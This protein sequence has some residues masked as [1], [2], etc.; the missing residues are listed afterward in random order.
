MIIKNFFYNFKLNNHKMLLAFIALL[1]AILFSALFI[2]LKQ[3]AAYFTYELNSKEGLKINLSLVN[4]GIST[5]SADPSNKLFLRAEVRDGSGNAVEMAHI[6]F[7]VSSGE[8]EIYTKSDRT[9]KFGECFA[10][11]I[12]PASLS[13]AAG[14]AAPKAVIKAELYG[15]VIS[16]SIEIN[17]IRTPVVFIHGY[18]ACGAVFDN[19]EEFLDTRGFESTAFTYK[20]ENGVAAG[21]AELNSFLLSL[22]ADYRSKGIQVEKFDV[23]AHSMGG[24]VARYYTGSS[25]YIYNNNVRK[26]IFISVPHHGSHVASLGMNYFNDK[27]IGDLVPDNELFTYVYPSMINKGLNSTVQVGNIIG[28]YDEVVSLESASLAEW[29]IRTEIFNVG[30]SNLSVNNLLDGSILESQNHKTVLNNKKVFERIEE[31]LINSLPYPS[32]R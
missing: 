21:A 32:K 31:M 7:Y 5:V 28:Q 11:Y 18:Q 16:S 19:M 30:D 29:N 1:A 14:D 10:S 4:Q 26:M 15:T 23:I 6:K 22:K 17:L 25:G 3:A 13:N 8:G 12:P 9:D 27:A 20:S 2:P 24:L